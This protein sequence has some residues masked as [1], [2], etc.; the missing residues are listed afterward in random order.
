MS[1][2]RKAPELHLALHRNPCRARHRE[3]FPGSIMHRGVG[4]A[5]A[6]VA[7]GW[8]GRDDAA[9]SRARAGVDVSRHPP[10]QERGLFE[11]AAL[12]IVIAGKAGGAIERRP[13]EFGCDQAVLGGEVRIW[14][15]GRREDR[16]LRMTAERPGEDAQAVA[17]R[18]AQD[19]KRSNSAADARAAGL[20]P[21]IRRRVLSPGSL[22]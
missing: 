19:R 17:F 11:A 12:L 2:L 22:S 21:A 4:H 16:N 8:P 14:C 15:P 1:P 18:N 9:V 20:A 10:E 6:A 13:E 3:Q 7:G 5:L